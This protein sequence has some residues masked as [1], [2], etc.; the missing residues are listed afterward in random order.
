MYAYQRILLVCE[1]GLLG[2][3]LSTHIWALANFIDLCNKVSVKDYFSHLRQLGLF[4]TFHMQS[5]YLLLLSTSAAISGITHGNRLAWPRIAP[6]K[7][8]KA[9]MDRPSLCNARFLARGSCKN[10]IP[11]NT[12]DRYVNLSVSCRLVQT[13]AKITMEIFIHAQFFVLLVQWHRVNMWRKT[14]NR[15]M[16]VRWIVMNW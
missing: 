7:F 12:D 4:F 6:F 9:I 15:I 8:L 5:L 14:M 10:T 13:D 11:W 1:Y 2:K 16:L 3:E